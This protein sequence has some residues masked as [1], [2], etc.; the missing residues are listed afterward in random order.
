MMGY[1]GELYANVVEILNKTEKFQGKYV[2]LK[3]S[4]KGRKPE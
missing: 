4:W 2:L 1:H 3:L